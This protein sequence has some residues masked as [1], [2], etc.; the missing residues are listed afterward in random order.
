MTC[1]AE[2]QLTLGSL[3]LPSPLSP[4]QDSGGQGSLPSCSVPRSPEFQA[5]GHPRNHSDQAFLP[6]AE[7]TGPR[8]SSHL[9]GGRVSTPIPPW[10]LCRL[11]LHKAPPS[12]PPPHQERGPVGPDRCIERRGGRKLLLNI[13]NPLKQRAFLYPSPTGLEKKER[14]SLRSHFQSESYHLIT[15]RRKL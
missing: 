11:T 15:T 5:R 1:P 10:P 2:I 9:P 3:L 4:S 12:P 13:K 8:R 7:E 14:L 6:L